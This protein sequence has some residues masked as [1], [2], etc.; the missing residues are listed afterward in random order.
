VLKIGALG[1]PQ[2]EQPTKKITIEK[3]A[4]RET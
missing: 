2:T 1:D 3:I 4:I